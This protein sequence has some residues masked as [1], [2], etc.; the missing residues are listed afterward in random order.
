MCDSKGGEVY[1]AI[2]TAG[3]IITVGGTPATWF[4]YFARATHTLSVHQNNTAVVPRKMPPE[5]RPTKIGACIVRSMFQETTTAVVKEQSHLVNALLAWENNR[6]CQCHEDIY[7]ALESCRQMVISTPPATPC[8]QPTRN[9]QARAAFL[10]KLDMS[11]S[12]APVSILPGLRLAKRGQA[13]FCVHLRDN[14]KQELHKR[15][16]GVNLDTVA[17]REGKD[18]P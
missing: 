5:Y 1:P 6:W 18:G 16:H 12:P 10:N 15:K 17:V 3:V 14:R 7:F 2:I 8:G 4:G 11:S 13:P 9:A